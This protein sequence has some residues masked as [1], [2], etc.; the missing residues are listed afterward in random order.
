MQVDQKLQTSISESD[1]DNSK[2]LTKK[3]AE[4][5]QTAEEYEK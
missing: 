3:V 5:E 4:L 2:N 1:L